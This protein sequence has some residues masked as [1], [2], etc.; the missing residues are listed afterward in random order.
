VYYKVL[1]FSDVTLYSLMA[2]NEHFVATSRFHFQS[3]WGGSR[4]LRNVGYYSPVD[5]GL[6]LFLCQYCLRVYQD[7]R[8]QS[9]RGLE[10][11]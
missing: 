2:S 1:V 6:I 11:S 7:W 5:I 9:P 10:C 8:S 4:F 3:I